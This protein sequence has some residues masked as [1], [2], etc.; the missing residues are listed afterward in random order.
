MNK[1]R[2]IVEE[3]VDKALFLFD[4]VR[5]IPRILWYVYQDWR[6]GPY[7]IVERGPVSVRRRILK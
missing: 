4:L 1:H 3:L 6:D 5:S 2:G 7:I